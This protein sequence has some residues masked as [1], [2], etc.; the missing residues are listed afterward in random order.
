ML[1][2]IN[3]YLIFKNYQEISRFKL[4]IIKKTQKGRELHRERRDPAGNRKKWLCWRR[5]GAGL[6][7]SNRDL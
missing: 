4:K 3:L 5:E 7:G 2:T 1:T 6:A